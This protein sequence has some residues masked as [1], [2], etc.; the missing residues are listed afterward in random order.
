MSA[1]LIVMPCSAARPAWMWLSMIRSSAMAGSDSRCC[2]MNWAWRS[3]W[4]WVSRPATVRVRMRRSVSSSRQPSIVT[5]SRSSSFV[6][7]RPATVPTETRWS[8]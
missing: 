4:F 2:A 3:A 1:S 8:L 5:R 7:L 6:M